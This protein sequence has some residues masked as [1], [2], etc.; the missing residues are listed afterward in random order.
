MLVHGTLVHPPH[1]GSLPEMQHGIHGAQSGGQ[2][3]PLQQDCV[4]CAGILL[5]SGLVLLPEGQHGISC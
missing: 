5:Q 1:A 2:E 3:P 4:Q